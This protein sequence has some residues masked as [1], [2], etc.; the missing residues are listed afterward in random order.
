MAL[1]T[2]GQ[3]SQSSMR[4]SAVWSHRESTSISSA[5]VI[6]APYRSSTCSFSV[7]LH[8]FASAYVSKDSDW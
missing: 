6:S 5:T 2:T 4:T 1:S 3:R 7:S 8:A